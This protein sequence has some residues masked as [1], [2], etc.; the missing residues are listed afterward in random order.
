[1]NG[2]MKENRRVPERLCAL[3]RVLWHWEYGYKCKFWGKSGWGRQWEKIEQ[4]LVELRVR[5]RGVSVGNE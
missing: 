1:M 4:P 3:E 5:E 2:D